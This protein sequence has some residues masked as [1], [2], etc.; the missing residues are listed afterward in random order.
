VD[1]LSF[2]DVQVH[3]L[4][5][6]AEQGTFPR[7]TESAVRESLAQCAGDGAEVSRA[8]NSAVDRG[9]VERDGQF[10]VVRKR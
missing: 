4:T 7:A 3:V 5:T 2:A 6:A 9:R 1:R 10:L 8:I